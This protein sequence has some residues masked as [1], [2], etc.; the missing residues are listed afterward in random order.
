MAHEDDPILRHQVF[1]ERLRLLSQ[2]ERNATFTA[3]L[4]YLLLAYIQWPVAPHSHVIGWTL[5]VALADLVSLLCCN[6]CL[7]HPPTPEQQRRWLNRQT[8][9]FGMSGLAWGLAKALLYVPGQLSHELTTQL[10]LCA[11]GAATLVNFCTFRQ[12]MVTF[13]LTLW[14]PSVIHF[15]WVG[16][17]LHVQLG[18]A[19]VVYI[20]ILLQYGWMISGDQVAGIQA[21]LENRR[22]AEKL[23]AARQATEESNH[24]LQRSNEE[25]RLALRT[26]NKLAT[27]DDLT[28]TFNRRYLMNHLEQD[29]TRARR[30]GRPMTLLMLDL[31]HFKAINDTWGHPV[32]DAV[33]QAIAV[34]L[35]VAL[36]D[37]DLLARYGG[38]EF[39]CLLPD[40]SVDEAQ[41]LAERLRSRV[42]SVPAVTDPT[43]ILV[44]VSIGMAEFRRDESLESWL[45]RADQALYDAK[46]QG[47]NR[48]ALA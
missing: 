36:R 40:T 30:H 31:D 43:P 12:V 28:G 23:A 24:E 15:L 4:G 8:L 34:R 29:V 10:F 41:V 45:A 27:H 25:L 19:S 39:I 42:A 32:G 44:S 13:I 5:L 33:L 26:I 14:V 17:T 37:S 18:I 21:A 38:E 35:Q 16:D 1:A 11:I 6:H 47:R 22:L 9:A 48:V 46:R 2:R 20:I 3:P 7:T